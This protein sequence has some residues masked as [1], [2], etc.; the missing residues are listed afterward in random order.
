MSFCAVFLGLLARRIRTGTRE[1][2]N[3]DATPC[4]SFL[5]PVSMQSLLTIRRRNDE[6]ATTLDLDGLARL[7]DM[8]SLATLPSALSSELSSDRLP[9]ISPPRSSLRPSLAHG[10]AA[11]LRSLPSSRRLRLLPPSPCSLFFNTSAPWA[12]STRPEPSSPSPRHN[13]TSA[14]RRDSTGLCLLVLLNLFPS[15]LTHA[16]VSRVPRQYLDA[17]SSAHR[18]HLHSP[19]P[20]GASHP[21][22]RRVRGD[23]QRSLRSRRALCR[24]S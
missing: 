1:R 24:P 12:V 4:I 10:R 11:P 23:L 6:T 18:R 8:P 20:R 16:T 7:L 13:W 15:P 3:R 19:G 17:A 5:I 2:T 21:T 14:D 9:S 22:R